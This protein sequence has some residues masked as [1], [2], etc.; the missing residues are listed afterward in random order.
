MCRVT[1]GDDAS[2]VR[3]HADVDEYVAAPA[4]VR[5][6]RARAQGA[7][8][9]APACAWVC[10]VVRVDGHPQRARGRAQHSSRAGAWCAARGLGR[11]QVA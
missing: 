8:L 10:F 11:A 5:R 3:L 6:G 1:S 7:A 9:R 4:C 2:P